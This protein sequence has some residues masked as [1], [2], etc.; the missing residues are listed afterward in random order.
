[1]NFNALIS[2]WRKIF[3]Y[4]NSYDQ[5]YCQVYELIGVESH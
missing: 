3:C 4:Q 5:G 1:M 2:S